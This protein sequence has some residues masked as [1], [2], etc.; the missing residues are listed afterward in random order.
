ME[1]ED[2][3]RGRK[4]WNNN[5]IVKG[6]DDESTNAHWRQYHDVSPDHPRIRLVDISPAS[7]SILMRLSGPLTPA[8]SGYFSERVLRAVSAGYKRLIINCED[9]T[10]TT[11]M[12]W[13]PLSMWG[14][15]LLI[16][17]VGLPESARDDIIACWMTITEQSFDQ[18][19]QFKKT[20]ADAIEYL[21]GV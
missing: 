17:F 21:C 4:L 20:E 16:V 9:L 2:S 19:F 6:F 1:Q 7:G 10:D 14:H 3:P 13:Y 15:A 12:N 8:S 11:Q 5:D 18:H